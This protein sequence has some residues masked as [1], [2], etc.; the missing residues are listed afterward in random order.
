MK[1]YAEELEIDPLELSNWVVEQQL[2]WKTFALSTVSDKRLTCNVTEE[3]FRV[4]HGHEIIYEGDSITRASI[5]YNSIAGLP[6]N[7]PK[8]DN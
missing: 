2:S 1:K 3:R 5:A 4:L 8:L 7:V 6:V